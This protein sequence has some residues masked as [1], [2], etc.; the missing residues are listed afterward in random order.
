[1]GGGWVCIP[2]ACD[3]AWAAGGPPG[4]QCRGA[5]ENGR[6]SGAASLLEVL[7]AQRG[8][9]NQRRGSAVISERGDVRRGA[10]AASGLPG[11]IRPGRT[12]V[13]LIRN[14]LIKS[15]L[16][17]TP[18]Q[19]L[20]NTCK[21]RIYHKFIM[22]LSA[23]IQLQHLT[24]PSGLPSVLL[25]SWDADGHRGS[26]TPSPAHRLGVAVVPL[27][28]VHSARRHCPAHTCA[29]AGVGSRVAAG[30]AFW[31][32]SQ[33]FTPPCPPTNETVANILMCWNFSEG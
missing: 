31:C 29:A 25:S 22:K 13:S 21:D 20:G 26:C 4:A 12:G 27:A 24:E 8:S 6:G 15:V 11:R 17:G 5:S 23:L 18:S 14:H 9:K 2:S 1:M 19:E 16:S 7:G 28:P 33:R 10:W 3:S 32:T 30:T